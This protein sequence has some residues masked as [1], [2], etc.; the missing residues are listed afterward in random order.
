[1][2]FSGQRGI[3]HRDLGAGVQQKVVGAGMVYGYLHDHLVAVYKT[4]GYTC[5][6]SRATRLCLQ[7]GI[8]RRQDYRDKQ[9]NT[10]NG[11]QVFHV[12]SASRA[13][14]EGTVKLWRGYLNR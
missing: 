5:D 1:M 6:I 7:K 11:E 3:D 12:H 13:R 2:E 14:G 9:L 4:E 8:N 10:A